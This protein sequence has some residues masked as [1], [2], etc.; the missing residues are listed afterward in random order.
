MQFNFNALKN[1][2]SFHGMASVKGIHN[3]VNT[4]LFRRPYFFCTEQQIALCE[5]FM[6]KLFVIPYL[7]NQRQH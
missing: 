6:K 5:S 1:I 4:K 2:M 7:T 3:N